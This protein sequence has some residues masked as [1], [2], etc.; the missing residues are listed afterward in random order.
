MQ[1]EK[2]W[3]IYIETRN[4]LEI[5][6]ITY[7]FFS[8][9]VPDDF[10]ENYDVNEV[11]L[12]TRG[13]NETAKEFDKVLKFSFLIQEKYPA[14]Y[15]ELFHF[16][17]EF[18]IDYYCY[19]KNES[20]AEQSFMNFF[21]NPEQDYDRLLSSLKKLL[22]Y[23]NHVGL[24]DKTIISVYDTIKN[25]DALIGEPEY[26]LSVLKFY[27]NFEY[28]HS[29]IT[30]QCQFEE[31]EFEKSLIPYELNLN[32]EVLTALLI[33]HHNPDSF[34]ETLV[35]GFVQN[36]KYFFHSVLGQFLREMTNRDFS[37]ALSGSLWDKMLEFWE[38]KSEKNVKD[39]NGYF[40]IN[41]ADFEEY[42]QHLSG[43]NFRDNRSEMIAVLWGSVYVYDFLLSIG[44]INQET[45]NKFKTTSNII[46][47][48]IINIHLC[49]LWNS[50]FVHQWKKPDSISEVEFNE[51]EKI[52]R[53]SLVLKNLPFFQLKS[54]IADELKNIGELSTYI[55]KGVKHDDIS[56]KN[57]VS[58]EVKVGR[59]DPC[60][61][62]SGK[63]YKKCCE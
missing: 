58:T 51:E 18:L 4:I 55:M 32:K 6:D 3:N 44:V 57:T 14:Q 49:D 61:C 50:N 13:H 17:D 47:G 15:Q 10:V 63:K 37:Y 22:Y 38:K 19:K 5:F 8:N 29:R 43:S 39:A 33:G 40:L 9:G 59:N 1:A 54:E 23:Q 35:N 28:Y 25:S 26:E 16:F 36:N 53:K 20:L 48:K 34:Q 45:F 31:D 12:E 52:F 42:L 7:D 46:K 24:V 62:G 27:I 60:S 21:N 41:T 56:Q 2:F 11:L 30:E